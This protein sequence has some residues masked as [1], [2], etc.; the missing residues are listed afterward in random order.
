MARKKRKVPF[1]AKPFIK[2]GGRK[3]M[4]FS[5]K[6]A[7]TV[8]AFWMIYRI[9]QFVVILI[10]PEVAESM[11]DLVKGVDGIQMANMGWYTGNSSVEKIA[12]AFVEKEE[13]KDSSSSKDDD[14]EEESD[15]NG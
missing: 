7:V 3:Y 8:T 10:R 13:I 4:Q 15:S 6:L 2:R 12:L 9:A 14:D 1:W 11:T 5:K